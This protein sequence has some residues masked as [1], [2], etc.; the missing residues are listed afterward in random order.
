MLTSKLV[1]KI[2][3]ALKTSTTH[4]VMYWWFV[5]FMAADRQAAGQDLAGP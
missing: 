2:Q 5:E 1:N 4:I 3:C